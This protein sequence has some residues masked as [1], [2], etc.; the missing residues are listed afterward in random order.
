[1]KQLIVSLL[2]AVSLVAGPQSAT[3]GSSKSEVKQAAKPV[4][5]HAVVTDAIVDVNS[6]SLEQLSALP[7]IGKVYGERI[8][9]NR[10][11]RAKN[12]LV[13]KGVVPESVYAK[14]RNKIIAKQ[15]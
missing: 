10:P 4:V 6:A 7:G 15:K 9:K 14:I 12:E 13:D 3:R 2:A 1:M 11:Y 8:I 5:T